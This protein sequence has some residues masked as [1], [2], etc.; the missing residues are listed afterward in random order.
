MV[1]LKMGMVSLSMQ[2]QLGVSRPVYGFLTDTGRVDDGGEADT[3][4][5]IHPRVEGEIALVTKSHLRG[6]G[7]DVGA[8][9]ASIDLVMPAIE[10]VDSRYQCY[11]FDQ[12][13]LIADNTSAACFVTG[14]GV[15]TD[16]SLDLAA[17]GVVLEKNGQAIE[18]GTGAAVLGHPAKAVAVLANMLAERGQEIPAGALILT[19]GI[20]PTVPVRKGDYVQLRCQH[21]GSTS[22]RFV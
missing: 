3:G 21:I 14:R 10:I 5:F 17:I 7:C 16:D 20:T 2:R 18:R 6:P 19:G 22:L 1:G 4:R 8:V 15:R 12:V 9:L 13:S 11:N